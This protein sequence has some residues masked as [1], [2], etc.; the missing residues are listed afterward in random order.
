MTSI[1]NVRE[2]VYAESNGQVTHDGA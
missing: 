1:E 2:I